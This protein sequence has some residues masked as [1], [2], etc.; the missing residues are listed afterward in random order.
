M[1]IFHV[2]TLEDWERARASGR[3]AT[4]TLGVSLEQ[5]GFIHASHAAQWEGVLARFYAECT[6]PLVL[7]EIEPS[8]LDCPVVEEPPAPGVSETFPHVYGPVPPAAVVSVT[9]L[10]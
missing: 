10:R 7:L 5:E 6:E 1:T 2:A 9:R 3:Y 4:S 8:L